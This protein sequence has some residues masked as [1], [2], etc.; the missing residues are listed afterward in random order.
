MQ[1]YELS[2]AAE[3]DALALEAGT[4]NEAHLLSLDLAKCQELD[5]E[6]RP[7]C[8]ANVE[9][10]SERWHNTT[11][12]KWTDPVQHPD[13]GKWLVQGCP[14]F[15]TDTPIIEYTFPSEDE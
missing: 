6:Y 14:D 7:E 11:Q 12:E 5:E 13:T 3:A 9:A 4:C 2:T 15:T 8:E 10:K 1:Y